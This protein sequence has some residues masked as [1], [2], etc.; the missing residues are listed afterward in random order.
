MSDKENEPIDTNQFDEEP[1]F[2]KLKKKKKS[3]KKVDFDTE[4]DATE[5][6]QPEEVGDDAPQDD[7]AEADPDAMFADLKKKKKKKS[8]PVEDDAAGE[9]ATPEGTEEDLDFGAL[10][11]KKK[12]KKNMAE[13]EAELSEQQGGD[14]DENN[15]EDS[16]KSAN[17]EAWLKSDRDYTYDELLGRVFN[18][19]RQNNPELVGEKKRYTIVPPSIHREGNKKTIFAN[20]ADISKRLHREPEHVIQFL[21][22]ELGTTGSVDGAQRLIIKG[23]F[24]QKQ[25]ENVLRR[26]IV[27]YVTCKTCKSP[28]TIMT[29]DNRLY[30][31][32][33]EACGSTRSVSAIK[34]GFKAQT[35][36]DRRA[37]RA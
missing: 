25:I 2:S 35:K 34:T 16:T 24:Q 23:R 18:I 33:C 21:F 20:V 13:F 10:K 3:K 5:Q 28:D 22:A 11:K 6:Q 26:Y 37:L 31:V 17:E 4:A 27:E 12:K 30:F 36:E 19:L 14:E 8:K 15:N 1:D 32:Q 7:D 9:E 29:K